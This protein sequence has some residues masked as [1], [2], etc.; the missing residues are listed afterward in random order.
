MEITISKLKKDNIFTDEFLDLKGNNH[1]DFKTKNICVLY[2]P[3]GTGKTSL[4]KVLKKVDS[5]YTVK[6]DGVTHTEKDMAFAHIISDQNDRNF[7]E[8]ETQDFILGEGIRREYD[9]KERI[10][11]NFTTLFNK[12]NKSLKSKFGINK[13]NTEFDGVILD[14][15]VLNYISDIANTKSKGNLIDREA[16]IDKIYSEPVTD[17]LEHDDDKLNFFIKDYQGAKSAIRT[18]IS[19]EFALNEKDQK[20]V[21]LEEQ[22]EAVSLLNRYSYL[23]D[24]LVCDHPIDTAEA[25]AKKRREFEETSQALDDKE[26]DIAEQIVKGLPLNDPFHIRDSVRTAISKSDRKYINNLVSELNSYKAIYWNQLKNHIIEEVKSLNLNTDL[27]EYKNLIK[28][29]PKF[30]SEDI[31]FIER[32]LNEALERPITLER[33]AD[34]NLR[35]LLGGKAFLNEERRNLSLSNGEQNFLSLS[36]E[37]LK[38]K[39][40]A[41]NLIVLDDPI[42]S[43]DS[44]YKNKLA[45][46]IMSF[47]S[48]KKALILTHNTDLIKLL[49]HQRQNCLNLYYFNNVVGESNGFTPINSNE[50]K[51]LLYIHQ[52]LEL[53]R[54]DIKNEIDNERDFAI[55]IV[56]FMRGY[57]QI[58]GLKEEKDKLTKIMHG[59]LNERIN[60]TDIYEKLFSDKVLTLA[61]VVSANDIIKLDSDK[62]S[63]LKD[64]QY[65]LLSKALRHTE[66]YLYLRMKVEDKLVRKFKVNTKN[67][68]ML[69]Q[70]ITNA[71]KGNKGDNQM[72]RVFFMSRKTLLNEFNHFEMDMNIFQ[73]AIDITDKALKKEKT[74]ILERLADF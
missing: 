71:F 72:H 70:I 52:F 10:N 1:L 6:V 45:Y 66:N 25:I 62:F 7:I 15:D 37:L 64:T 12:L 21:K 4:S 57:C 50:I 56:P 27:A 11:S 5:E 39:N 38:A 20:I 13:K 67:H 60:I 73:P 24:C 19:Y 44:I 31:L 8:G 26:K 55:S 28:N 74:Q 48:D 22:N 49:E 51:I 43:F 23:D 68:Y 53:L 30:A 17:N 47:L 69:T 65:P 36:F 63:P 29:K 14:K 34:N 59:Y 9:L 32:F 41:C 54:C 40:S 35:L 18:I 42:S 2:G 58:L 61:H 16:L 3:N 33:D 46:A